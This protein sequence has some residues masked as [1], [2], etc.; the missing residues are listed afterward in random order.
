MVSILK[1]S[2]SQ[3]PGQSEESYK[4]LC[5]TTMWLTFKP[6]I[7]NKSCSVTADQLGVIK[8]EIKENISDVKHPVKKTL[9]N[10]S[11]IR[12]FQ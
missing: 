7:T 5:V 4:I 2:N 6:D 9:N 1:R 12:T 8:G 3:A 11:N 10:L